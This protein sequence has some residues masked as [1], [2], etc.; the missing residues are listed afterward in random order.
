MI[1][2]KFFGLDP[3]STASCKLVRASSFRCTAGSFRPWAQARI[4]IFPKF[5]DSI[6]CHVCLSNHRMSLSIYVAITTQSII[7]AGLGPVY[8]KSD[9]ISTKR[10][11]F[12]EPG[13]IASSLSE[14][15]QMR[16]QPLSLRNSRSTSFR[17]IN[18]HPITPLWVPE[19]APARSGF[20]GGVEAREGCRTTCRC[21]N[22][23]ALLAIKCRFGNNR[24][25]DVLDR[26]ACR[27]AAA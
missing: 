13:N 23:N 5:G 12:S 2:A 21:S 1:C 15:V 8:A 10:A 19:C 11:K 16:R 9:I 7:V 4:H 6:A 26:R 17:S 3:P 18:A 14:R 25:P 27:T 24:W 20:S 22:A